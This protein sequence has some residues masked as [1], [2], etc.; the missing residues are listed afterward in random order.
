MMQ[1]D[2]ETDPDVFLEKH[3]ADLERHKAEHTLIFSLCEVAQK[4][5]RAGV[6]FD[7]RFT[8]VSRDGEYLLSAVQTPP[9]NL[10]LSRGDIDAAE[11]LS[12]MFLAQGEIFPGVVGPTDVTAAFS[13]AWSVGGGARF[14]EYMDQIIYAIRK[15]SLPSDVAGEF[16][17][18]KAGEEKIAA[19]WMAAFAIG[20]GLPKTEIPTA[21][22]SARKSAER[23][24]D[25]NLAFW[26]VKGKPVAQAAFSGTGSVGRVSLVYTPEEHRGNG[27][28]SAVTAHLTQHLLNSGRDMCVLYADARNPVSNSIYRKIG[29][30]FVGRSSLYV[31]EQAGE[32]NVS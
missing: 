21:E 13:S 19:E 28:A 4:K 22:D 6:S 15:A 12:A 25:G 3:G 1:F 16:R 27:Y 8:S 20:A 29:Y 30:E 9:R 18:A 7:I 26:C 32:E 31:L 5:K 10:V 24:A 11:Q 2:F 14:D 23:V 17:F